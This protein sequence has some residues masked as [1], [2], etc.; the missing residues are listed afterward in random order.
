M[1]LFNLFYKMWLLA[2]PT[3]KFDIQ[4]AAEKPDDF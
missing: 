4:G 2:V 3:S 1:E